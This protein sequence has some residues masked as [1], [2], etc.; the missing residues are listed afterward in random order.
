METDYSKHFMHFRWKI[1]WWLEHLGVVEV[2]G[3][4]LPLNEKYIL[5]CFIL[6]DTTSTA[7]Q[8]IAVMYNVLFPCANG[9]KKTVTSFEMP[10]FIAQLSNAMRCSLFA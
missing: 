8:S 5:F 3:E 9:K 1:K 6:Q 4:M 10:Q 2:M 7:Y